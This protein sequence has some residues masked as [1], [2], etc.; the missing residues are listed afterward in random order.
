MID[1][2]EPESVEIATNHDGTSVWV[3]VDGVCAFRACRIKDLS[4][5]FKHNENG[6]SAAPPEFLSAETAA[7]ML[8]LTKR[9]FLN[10]SQRGDIK[11]QVMYEGR[12]YWER[13]EIEKLAEELKE[14][15]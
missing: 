2:T 10:L 9:V 1:I 3:N 4:F 11:G 14:G 13:S 6:E 12:R 5:D 8:N 7:E 15:I